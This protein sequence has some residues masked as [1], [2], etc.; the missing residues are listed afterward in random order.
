[1]KIL[2][3]GGTGYIGSHTYVELTNAGYDVVI[4]DNLCNSNIEVLNSLREIT[5]VKPKFYNIDL[6]NK[7]QV[8]DFFTS[9]SNFDAIIHFAAL[10]AVGESVQKPLAYYENNLFGLINILTNMEKHNI[11]GMVFSSSC[12]VYGQPDHLPVVESTPRKTAESPY[13][14]TKSI[15]ED[16][17]RDQCK[18]STSTQIIAL[19]YFNPIGAHPSALIGELPIGTPNNLIPFITQTAAGMREYL[20]VFGSNYNTPDGTAIRDY[21]DV[22]DLAKAHVVAID[23]I[24]NKKQE[25][26]FE[27]F[28]IGTG[29]GR[30]VLEV[31]T[32]FETATNVKLN[33]KIVDRREGD[34]EKIWADTTISNQ[35]LNWEAKTSLE[36]SLSNSWKW[37]KKIRGI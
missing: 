13:G 7:V 6:S 31:I 15:A 32:A 26:N 9:N 4:I 2:V 33:Y 18:A 17:I 5:G 11:K 29:L 20:S 16:I 1:M 22:I 37:E 3:T 25:S 19:R 27:Y 21:I 36:E 8:D 12:T 28:N 30:S 24:V 23:R 14:N 34:I 10:K 35:K